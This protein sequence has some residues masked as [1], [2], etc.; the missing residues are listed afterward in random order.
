M[1]R[2]MLLIAEQLKDTYEGDPWFGKPAVQLLQQLEK[3]VPFQK[4]ANQH[5]IL[6]LVWHMGNWK[7]FTISRI[8]KD[9]SKPVRYFEENDWRELNHNDE[10]QWQQGL[11]FFHQTQNEL[12]EVIQQQKDELLLEQVPGRTYDFRKLLYGIAQHD[13]YHLGQIAFIYKLIKEE[14]QEN[15]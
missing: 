5:S 12:V 3:E 1:N 13:I 2:E 7:Q 9:E 14:K 8:R 10:Q 6:E 15:R 4:P 11:Y